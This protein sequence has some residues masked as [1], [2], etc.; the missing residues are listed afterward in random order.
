MLDL[1]NI[2]KDEYLEIATI[3]FSMTWNW[4]R[5]GQVFI[6][7]TR[8]SRGSRRWNS[9]LRVSQFNL[10]YYYH[11]R[12]GCKSVIFAFFPNFWS[13]HSQINK[14]DDCHRDAWSIS[15]SI[16]PKSKWSAENW[17]QC[18]I[19]WTNWL[20]P[21]KLRVYICFYTQKCLLKSLKC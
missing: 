15:H 18:S 2:F 9:E 12:Q 21:S 3:H 14:I 1:D 20:L 7:N 5:V 6:W 11:S 13:N 8:I 10:L 19:S 4:F 17:I 16:V